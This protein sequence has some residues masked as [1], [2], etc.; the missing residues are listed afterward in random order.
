MCRAVQFCSLRNQAY[1]W[2]RRIPGSDAY[3][4]FSLGTRDW[5]V[6]RQLS[7]VLTL[8]SERSLAGLREGSMT[9]EQVKAFTRLCLKK[10]QE[11]L[12]SL[13]MLALDSGISLACNVCRCVAATNESNFD[14]QVSGGNRLKDGVAQKWVRRGR[15]ARA[16]YCFVDAADDMDRVREIQYGV[17]ASGAAPD[18]GL[19]AHPTSR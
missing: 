1:F 10:Y 19:M 18:A 12:R 7:C 5:R 13:A 17:A 16:S 8:E 4:D 6:A 2:R 14:P 9:E 3:V 11:K 15:K